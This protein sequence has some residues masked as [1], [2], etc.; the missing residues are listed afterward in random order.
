MAK[1]V[2]IPDINVVVATIAASFVDDHREQLIGKFTVLS[3][4][5]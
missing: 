1:L 3:I 4:G 5:L 2:D